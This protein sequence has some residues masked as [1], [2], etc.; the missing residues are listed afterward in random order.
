MSKSYSHDRDAN[1]RPHRRNP[2]A[3][4]ATSTNTASHAAN[5]SPD[6]LSLVVIK[7]HNCVP[8]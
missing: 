4:Y 6:N 3:A 2:N 5:A 7:I 8:P 1:R